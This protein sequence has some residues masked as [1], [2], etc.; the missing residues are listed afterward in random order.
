MPVTCE[1]MVASSRPGVFSFF[2]SAAEAAAGANNTAQHKARTKSTG[3]FMPD[4][5]PDR[6]ALKSP[7]K[8]AIV[9]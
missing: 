2:V 6:P 4:T 9:P 3:R 7:Q 8:T 5:I 1:A